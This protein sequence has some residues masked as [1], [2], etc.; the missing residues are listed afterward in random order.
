MKRIASLLL[1]VPLLTASILAQAQDGFQQR[2]VD[3]LNTIYAEDAPGAAV[4]VSRDGEILLNQGFGLADV[5][6]QVAA[7]A[8]HVFRL[9]SVTKQY[10][11]A[12]LLSLVEQG[13]VS[14]DD[15]ISKFLPDFP[16]AEV[17]VEQL[18]NHTSGIKSYTGIEGYMASGKIRAD[19]STEELVAVFA[20]EAVDFAP[21]EQWAYNNSGYVLVGAV[22]EAVTGQSWN[23]Y[24]REALLLPNGIEL[25]DAY[26]D[27]AVV[28]G[29]VQGYNGPLEDLQR[30]PFLSMTQPHAAGALMATAADVDRW[31]QTL[32]NGKVLGDEIYQ[33]MITPRGAAV[34]S[35][36]GFGITVGE[37]FGEPSLSH[38]GGIFGFTTH[39][40]YL[41]DDKLSIVVLANRTGPGWSP[42]D[43]SLRLAALA[44]DRTYP[45]DRARVE[46]N[47][48]QLTAVQGTYQIN[49]DEFRTIR[50]EGGQLISQRNGGVE[51]SV[52]PVEGDRLAFASSLS[53]FVIERNDA[54]EV[55]AVALGNGMGGT[56]ERAEKVSE[57][58]RARQSIEVP[59]EQLEPLTGQYQLMPKF[60]LTVRVTDGALE[61][62]ASGQPAIGM[63]AETPTRFYNAQ[64]GAVIEF[65][66]PEDGKATALTLIQGGQSMPAQR[67]A[68]EN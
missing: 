62:Q 34:E 45:I 51:F 46:W 27:T 58:V 5:E 18:L 67:V 1:T 4:V 22:I 63:L 36:Y 60:V 32:H 19:L 40:L 21:G 39:A 57:E 33:Q 49:E 61:V 38:S 30:A 7:R 8:E 15:P 23:D 12:A 41:P 6:L 20:D 25:T 66:L 52:F 24:L 10:A 55:T 35:T 16:V 54:G 59:V 9:A 64:I 29:R 48:E 56:P 2:A 47:A 37:W 3:M 65:E 26:P 17:T 68:K 28:P 42:R 13:K 50:F 53:A 44:N 43:V 14:L 11:A 31:Q